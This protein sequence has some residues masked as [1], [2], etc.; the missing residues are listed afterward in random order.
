VLKSLG[1]AEVPEAEIPERLAMV[2]RRQAFAD[3]KS[4]ED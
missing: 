3:I 1:E 4:R 2:A